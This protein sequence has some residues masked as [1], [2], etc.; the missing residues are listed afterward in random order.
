METKN[1]NIETAYLEVDGTG[2]S[3]VNTAIENWKN[4]NPHRV[5]VSWVYG[6]VFRPAQEP[7]NTMTT[8]RFSNAS[9]S[10]LD[11]DVNSYIAARSASWYFK[12]ISHYEAAGVHYAV[13]T[14]IPVHVLG[15]NQHKIVIHHKPFN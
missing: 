14:A 6:F 9:P 1:V 2:I 12:T 8:V 13:I 3:V 10:T 11:T 4:A 15:F 7:F 5:I